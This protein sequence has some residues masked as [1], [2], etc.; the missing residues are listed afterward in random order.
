M[1][2]E[3]WPDYFR[4]QHASD[5]SNLRTEP[6]TEDELGLISGPGSHLDVRKVTFYCRSQWEP[7]FP[8]DL[9]DTQNALQDGR[10]SQEKL[11]VVARGRERCG[12]CHLW[13]ASTD[14]TTEELSTDKHT[15]TLSVFLK[16]PVTSPAPPRAQAHLLSSFVPGKLR[17]Y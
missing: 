17:E 8:G 12:L 14:R 6:E 16:L 4:D 9:Q 7:D 5:D 13:R 10:L 2:M 15:G 1:I 3:M 11:V